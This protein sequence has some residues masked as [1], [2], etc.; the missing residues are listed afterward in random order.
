MVG[1]VKMGD[2]LVSSDVSG[3]AMANQD[4][5][6]GTIIGKALEDFFGQTGTVFA[7]VDLQ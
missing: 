7:R 1:P 3:H 4:P 6:P 5:R 2:L